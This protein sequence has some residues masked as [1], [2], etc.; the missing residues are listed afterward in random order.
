M[1]T[2]LTAVT[3][4]VLLACAQPVLAQSHDTGVGAGAD[5]D[6]TRAR[7]IV[8]T[9]IAGA[10]AGYETHGVAFPIRLG[11]ELPLLRTGPI[12]HHLL[13]AAEYAHFSRGFIREPEVLPG[14]QLD[15]G[16]L[17][18][19][20]RLF[21]FPRRGLHVDAGAGVALLRDRIR[22]ELP[23]RRFTSAETRLGVPFGFGLGWT[24]G[25]HLDLALRYSQEVMVLGTLR[26][27]QTP[28][29]ASRRASSAAPHAIVLSPGSPVFG[30][31]ELG[32]GVRL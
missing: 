28:R 25:R 7:L 3:L 31:A 16:S 19:T 23:G 12:R 13:L 5:R 6:E 27:S 22:M 29:E 14:V 18:A 1:T 2:R 21:P 10:L 11:A 30:Q 8:A 24:V 20:W 4:M 32:L 15:V 26:G 17:W 9:G